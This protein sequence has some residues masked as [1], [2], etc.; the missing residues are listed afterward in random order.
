[1]A[2]APTSR[3]AYVFLVFTALFWGGNA[4]ADTAAIGSAE[5][6]R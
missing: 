3:I 6:R 2:A 4:V 1:M 5:S